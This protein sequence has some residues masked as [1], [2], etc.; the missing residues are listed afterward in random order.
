VSIFAL[1]GSSF[2][3]V[4]SG[5]VLMAAEFTFAVRTRV[6]FLKPVSMRPTIYAWV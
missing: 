5:V 2:I 6:T 3:V 4:A 1:C